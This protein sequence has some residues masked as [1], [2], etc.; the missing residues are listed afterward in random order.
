M[1]IVKRPAMLEKRLA[2][3]DIRINYKTI[4]KKA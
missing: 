2:L 3:L 4:L 1:N